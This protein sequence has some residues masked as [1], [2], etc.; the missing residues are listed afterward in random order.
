[1]GLAVGTS[2]VIIALKS[3]A[4]FAKYLDVLADLGLGVNWEL[5]AMFTVIGAAG[6]FAGNWLGGRMPQQR[7]REA[8]AAF[9][10]VMGT[11]VI[12]TNL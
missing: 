3:L 11:F 4:G 9:L 12:Y 5:I 7:L 8:F 1:M 2:L 10:V 6:T